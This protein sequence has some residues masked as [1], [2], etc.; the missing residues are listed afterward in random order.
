MLPQ[1]RERR[2]DD[3][4]VL[5][6]DERAAGCKCPGAR[7]AGLVPEAEAFGG[8]LVS[9]GSDR[10]HQR[11]YLVGGI[12]LHAVLL[13]ELMEQDGGMTIDFLPHPHDVAERCMFGR[14]SP[15]C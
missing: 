5:L 6:H 15:R 2:R 8:I 1:R 10:S 12:G 7:R 13:V 11:Q 14:H 3:Q 4:H 9:P